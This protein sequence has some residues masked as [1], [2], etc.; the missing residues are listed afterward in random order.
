MFGNWSVNVCMCASCGV[1]SWCLFDVQC[2]A[3]GVSMFACVPVVVSV[4]G[5]FLV[6]NVWQLEC[7][8]LHVCLLWCLFLVSFWC[9]MFGN[10]SVNVYMCACCG[11]CSWC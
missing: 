5:V 7:Q 11:V 1:C 2:L 4:L 6:F 8:C 10:W 9:S 3:T